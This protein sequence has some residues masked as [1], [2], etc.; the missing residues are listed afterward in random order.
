M[1][2]ERGLNCRLIFITEWTTYNSFSF[3]ALHFISPL[4]IYSYLHILLFFISFIYFILYIFIYF[5]IFL[6]IYNIFIILSSLLSLFPLFF[7]FFS[8]NFGIH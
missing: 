4:V 2:G 3:C 5:Y 6:Y 1:R 8:L 7:V